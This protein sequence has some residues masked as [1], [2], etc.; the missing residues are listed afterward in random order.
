MPGT[1]PYQI[2]A[3]DGTLLYVGVTVVK[4]GERVQDAVR[5]AVAEWKYLDENGGTAAT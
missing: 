5:R 4:P 2:Y 1:A 3:P